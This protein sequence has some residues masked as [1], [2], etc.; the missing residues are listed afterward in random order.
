MGRYLLI[1]VKS[2]GNTSLHKQS[3]CFHRAFCIATSFKRWYTTPVSESGP[4][5]GEVRT[6][7][8]GH[9]SQYYEIDCWVDWLH[10]LVISTAN[11]IIKEKT[12]CEH[13]V[14]LL[15]T[16][17]D[18]YLFECLGCRWV[19]VKTALNLESQNDQYKWSMV[20]RLVKEMYDFVL[21]LTRFPESISIQQSVSAPPCNTL[22]QTFT[23][24]L[25]A[26]IWTTAGGQRRS[27]FYLS[28][29]KSTQD[30]HEDPWKYRRPQW[31]GMGREPAE[32]LV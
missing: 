19:F 2:L 4:L 31:E 1:L 11:E 17:N 16:W 25:Q 18:S 26:W 28:N 24:V 12:I 9:Y 21:R 32:E 22:E 23:E 27:S 5:S 8:P 10:C 29:M 6:G 30:N 3:Q 13:F 7:C 14:C 20:Q 15:D